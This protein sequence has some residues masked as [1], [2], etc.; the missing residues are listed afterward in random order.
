MVQEEDYW[1]QRAKI[2]WLK[3]GDMN[4]SFF[5]KSATA[6]HKKKKVSKLVDEGGTEVH[7]Q[8]ELCEVVKQ[9]FDDI[10][11]PKSGEQEPVFNLIQRRVTAEDNIYLVAPITKVEIQQ[12]LFQMQPDKSPGPDGFNPAFYQR[13]WE[14]CGDDIFLAASNW[15]ERGYFPTSLNET[16]ICLIPKCDNPMSMKDLRPISLCN[17]LYKMISKVLANRLKICLDKCVS[18]EQSA[19]VEDRSILDNT[20]IQGYQ[21]RTGRSD[22]SD[23][24]RS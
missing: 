4:T 1:K 20:L 17:V 11:K 8:E 15:L 7:T 9:Y 16:N 22:R 6:R 12:A 2:H 5:H 23:R 14:Q 10:F 19:F 18:Q 13:F 24:E 3:E 21:N